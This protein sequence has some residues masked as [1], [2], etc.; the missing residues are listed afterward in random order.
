MSAQNYKQQLFC[1]VHLNSP[2]SRKLFLD[3][4]IKPP[5]SIKSYG[6]K[7][8]KPKMLRGLEVHQDILKRENS[9]DKRSTTT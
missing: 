4:L 3:G 6:L 7:S 2:R 9:L 5:Y 1:W 8:M